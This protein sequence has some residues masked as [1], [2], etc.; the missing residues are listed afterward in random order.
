MAVMARGAAA[1]LVLLLTVLMASGVAAD[2]T[3][4]RGDK[5]GYLNTNVALHLPAC[6]YEGRQ[7][8]GL[9]S[10]APPCA[11]SRSEFCS[12]LPNINRLFIAWGIVEGVRR[13]GQRKEQEEGVREG[14][15]EA[16]AED[17]RC[18]VVLLFWSF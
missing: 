7:V 18:R 12:S 3:Y 6:R 8:W 16:G 2:H 1:A 15:A 10:T 5:V 13:G 14:T 4:K 11:L 9:E 17:L